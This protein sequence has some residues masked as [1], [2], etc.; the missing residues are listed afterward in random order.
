MQPFRVVPAP[1][2][3]L[4]VWRAMQDYTA[5]RGADGTDQVWLVEHEPVYT[6]GQA[7][8]REHLLAPGAIPV[9]ATDRGGQVTYH[10]PG[11]VLAY[12]MCDL[13]RAGYFVKEYVR[14]LEDAVIDTLAELGI[15]HA[16]RYPGAPGVYVP[17][18]PGPP[19]GAPIH[20][21]AKVAALGVKVRGGCTYHGVAL[22]VDMDLAPFSGIDPCGYQGLATADIASLGG[23]ASPREA[24]DHLAAAIVRRL[25]GGDSPVPPLAR[26]LAALAPSPAAP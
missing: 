16:T 4:P 23:R 5:A 10:G 11:Q 3:Y 13:R 14:R 6:L 20:H 22:N 8:R 17:L 15:E 7:G 26:P 1:T 2:P 9:V 24:G 19:E 21:Y 12:V 18:L 25:T